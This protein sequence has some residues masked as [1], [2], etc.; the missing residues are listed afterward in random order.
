[1]NTRRMKELEKEIHNFI[2]L[3]SE[4]MKNDD[5]MWSAARDHEGT[6]DESNP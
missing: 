5:L 1:M 6:C 3:L 4:S 2:E